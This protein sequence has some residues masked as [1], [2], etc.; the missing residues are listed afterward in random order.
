[1]KW[2]MVCWMMV[3]ALWMSTNRGIAVFHMADEKCLLLSPRPMVY[4]TTNSIRTFF[5]LT[6]NGTMFFG[7]G[8][9]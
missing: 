7:G 9:E 1:M 5:Y 2:F 8:K 3:Q 4:R 6:S